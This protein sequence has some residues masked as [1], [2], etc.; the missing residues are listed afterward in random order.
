[1]RLL[2]VLIVFLMSTSLFHSNSIAQS[3]SGNGSSSL[4][5]GMKFA[6]KT[7][8]SKY[9]ADDLKRLN[10]PSDF[11]EWVKLTNL[12]EDE[13]SD[14]LLFFSNSMSKLGY[15]CTTKKFQYVTYKSGKI[16][17]AKGDLLFEKG[18]YYYG[19]PTGEGLV[20]T[21]S[22]NTKLMG[23]YVLG[24]PHGVMQ[25]FKSPNDS[26]A[27]MYHF[28]KQLKE[29]TTLEHDGLTLKV[30]TLDGQPLLTG[31]VTE[32]S[33][34]GTEVQAIYVDGK[35]QKLLNA[36]FA[37]DSH[38]DGQLSADLLPDGFGTWHIDPKEKMGFE[39]VKGNF[40]NGKP[41]AGELYIIKH[42][43]YWLECTI[44]ENLLPHAPEGYSGVVWT[45]QREKD[46]RKRVN[47][48]H[49]KPT[50]V[51]FDKISNWDVDGYPKGMRLHG[52]TGEV[53]DLLIPHGKGELRV[54]EGRLGA[55]NT[56]TGI[57]EHGELKDGQ[58]IAPPFERLKALE[59]TEK[60]TYDRVVDKF[61]EIAGFPKPGLQFK[62]LTETGLRAEA[63]F[64]IENNGNGAFILIMDKNNK[65]TAATVEH[66]KN[67]LNY[68]GQKIK[69]IDTTPT[70]TV[71]LSYSN[72]DK[73][74][75]DAGYRSYIM[76]YSKESLQYFET[77]TLIVKANDEW[78]N[79]FIYLVY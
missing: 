52:Y 69:W 77:L 27:V 57:F 24:M 45:Y 5:D 22:R 33:P 23:H 40:K 36:V 75:N 58:W 38:F 54:D 21:F 30:Y 74:N 67:T 6:L 9:S 70:E 12:W 48:E 34:N 28:G 62:A 18:D 14:R 7:C 8:F 73:N 15:N 60:V 37:N 10:L 4:T 76:Q 51:K 11:D 65:A 50:T 66:F 31:L 47:Y 3:N 43:K 79:L 46:S 39:S 1:M 20:R 44:D 55:M 2:I 32:V 59:K 71:K 19:Y 16:P 13:D 56:W 41:I 49:G 64:E 78:A 35:R 63:I 61:L 53:D 72:V 26:M 68:E 42:S 25:Y 17:E 29:Q